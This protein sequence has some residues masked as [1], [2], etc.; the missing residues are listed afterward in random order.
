ML[1][2]NINKLRSE[3]E[4]REQRKT[5]I[6]EKILDLCYQRILNNNKKS[7]D[8]SCTYIV[9]NVVFGLPLYDV[10]EC[11]TFIIKKLTEKEFD[12]VFAY[13]TTIHISW[14]PVDKYKSIEYSNSG[15]NSYR[16]THTHNTQDKQLSISSYNDYKNSNK[17]K[18]QNQKQQQTKNYKA[19][20]DYSQ[21]NSLIYDPDDINLFQSKLDNLFN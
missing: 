11:V 6:Y 15:S 14:K 19:I 3:V 2:I 9:P 1:S 10:N 17:A 4:A 12:I 8:Y 20:D 7:D 21:S 16:S 5:K 13:P 18:E